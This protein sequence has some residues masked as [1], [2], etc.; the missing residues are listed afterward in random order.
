MHGEKTELAFADNC[1]AV[2]AVF[3]NKE[4]PLASGRLAGMEMAKYI[5][6]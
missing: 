2:L 5:A 1:N 4:H 3:M 6:E